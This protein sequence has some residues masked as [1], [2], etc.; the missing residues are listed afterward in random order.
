[1]DPIY[2]LA[3]T[4]GKITNKNAIL[5]CGFDHAVNRSQLDAI[6]KWDWR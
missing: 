3:L 4:A 1:M 6:E 5:F 2:G